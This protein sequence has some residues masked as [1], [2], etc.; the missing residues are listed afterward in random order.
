M[1]TSLSIA[2]LRKNIFLIVYIFFV[3]TIIVAAAYIYTNAKEKIINKSHDAF[4]DRSQVLE[5]EVVNNTNVVYVMQNIYSRHID[6]KVPVNQLNQYIKDIEQIAIN[7]PSKKYHQ[8]S[9]GGHLGSYTVINTIF[10]P[11]SN[12]NVNE[13]Y[14]QQLIALLNMQDFQSAILKINSS[15]V[16][17]YFLSNTNTI[18][19]IYPIVSLEK[20]VSDFDNIESFT[21]Q[22]YEVYNEFSPPEVNPDA[23]HFWTEPYL[24]RAGNG[25]M[26]TCAIPTYKDGLYNGV[27]GADI[28][29]EFLNK[30][31]KS[32]P[33]LSG[34]SFLISPKGVVITASNIS[35]QNEEELVLF[36]DIIK[37]EQ[38]KS[39]DILFEHSLE[40]APWNYVYIVSNEK[41]ISQT[42]S[43]T[44]VFNITI[45]MALIALSISYFFV[46][47]FFIKPALLAEEKVKTINKDLHSTK[48]E[49]QQNL[50]DLKNTQQK[51]IESEKLAALGVLVTGMAHEINT[52]LGVVIT[53]SSCAHEDC[54]NIKKKFIED[55]MTKSDFIQFLTTMDKSSLIIS[56]N[57]NRVADMVKE[58]K[59]ISAQS[60]YYERS[61]FNF[62]K[63]LG[64]IVK[65]FHNLHP[66]MTHNITIECDDFNIESYEVAFDQIITNLIDNSVNHAFISV[67]QGEINIKVITTNT[68]YELYYS[69]NGLGINENEASK[70]F[71][72]FYTKQR[73]KSIGL[74][75]FIVHNIVNEK[76]K[77]QI[78]VLDNNKQGLAF[79]ISWPIA[80][81]S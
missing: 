78:E 44:K 57:L 64:H 63:Y 37:R 20:I 81:T 77:G 1:S 14:V 46:I 40:N 72:P 30:F 4:Y 26:V 13:S 2:K 19:S 55:Q 59:L 53:S 67:Q 68:S 28:T 34:R 42:L 41:I 51:M 75:L 58:F 69:D 76:L 16:M 27:I 8:L 60:S 10:S 25:M 62:K 39:E 11:G 18:S 33:V 17:S 22:A 61:N 21:A 3:V 7:I 24:D 50:I 47:K 35:Y 48:D 5:A 74:G 71:E 9:V 29:L 73:A 6:Q 79:K 54:E 49:L 15:L 31:V 43:E 65:I 56:K 12:S 70:I 52:P 32:S 23:K 66:Q 45:L 80:N 38:E 36:D